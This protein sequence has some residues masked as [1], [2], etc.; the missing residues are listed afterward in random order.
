MFKVNGDEPKRFDYMK[1]AV[2]KGKF[3]DPETGHAVDA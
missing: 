2:M 3:I 1:R